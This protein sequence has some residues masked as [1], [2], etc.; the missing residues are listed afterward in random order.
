MRAAFPRPSPARSVTAMATTDL[1]FHRY[2]RSTFLQAPSSVLATSLF[3]S[4]D[5]DTIRQRPL[6]LRHALSAAEEDVTIDV[7]VSISTLDQ[8]IVQLHEHSLLRRCYVHGSANLIRR[9]IRTSDPSHNMLA[10]TIWARHAKVDD[11]DPRLLCGCTWEIARLSISLLHTPL[12][13]GHP[14]LF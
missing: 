7:T 5:H 12:A 3:H 6:G 14:C 1:F 13:G 4:T 9:H 8:P 2:L 10:Q 11:G